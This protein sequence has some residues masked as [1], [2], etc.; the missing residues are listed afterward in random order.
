MFISVNPSNTVSFGRPA[1]YRLFLAHVRVITQGMA[2]ILRQESAHNLL[3]EDAL[4]CQYLIF[5]T[6]V[7]AY[8]L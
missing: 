8:M 4:V 5:A 6:H 2:T 7:N 1:T 3:M